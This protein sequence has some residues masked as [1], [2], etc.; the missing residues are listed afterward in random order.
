MHIGLSA[1]HARHTGA[2][3]IGGSTV[4]LTVGVG[5]SGR[6]IVGSVASPPAGRTPGARAP[7]CSPVHEEPRR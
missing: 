5:R 4:R 2:D 1:A 3:P 7:R 6:P